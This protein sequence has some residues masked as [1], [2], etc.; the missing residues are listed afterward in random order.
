MTRKLIAGIAAAAIALSVGAAPAQ[1]ASDGEKIALWLLGAA[2]VAAVIDDKNK[3]A[4]NSPHRQTIITRSDDRSQQRYYD[5]DDRWDRDHRHDRW[6][7]NDRRGRH[8]SKV[9]PQSCLRAG[10]EVGKRHSRAESFVSMQCLARR[11]AIPSMPRSCKASYVNGRYRYQGY[12]LGCLR[13]KGY[14]VRASR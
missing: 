8:S 1:A 4:R 2:A 9:V 10:F 11:G 12:D 13:D 7:D 14:V 5:R 3:N 6:R